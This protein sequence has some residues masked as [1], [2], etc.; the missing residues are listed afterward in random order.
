M[1]L[2]GLS[3]RPLSQQ[4]EAAAAMV[5]GSQRRSNSENESD[6]DDFGAVTADAARPGATDREARRRRRHGPR[7]LPG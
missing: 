5:P 2:F 3:M 1:G 4:L 7:Q 6:S